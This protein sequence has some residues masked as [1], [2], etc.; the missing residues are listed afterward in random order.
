MITVLHVIESLEIGGAEHQLTAMLLRSDRR[1]FHHVVC[2]LGTAS[3]YG[4]DLERA[5]FPVYALALSPPR[6]LLPAFLRLRRLVSDIRPDV[7][8]VSLFWSGV[9]GRFIARLARIP[10]LT[11]LVNTSYEPEWVEEPQ[12]HP[13]KVA[14]V[15]W[16]DA[17]TSRRWG[18]WFLSISEPIKTSAVRRLGLDPARITIVPRGLEVER[19]TSPGPHEVAALR[20]DLW[21]DASPA[22]LSVGRLV[23][24]K[25]YRYAIEAMARVVT[26]FPTARLCIAGEG[27]LRGK[28]TALVH[29]LGLDDHVRLLGSRRDVPALLAACDLFIFPQ[30]FGGFGNAL[31]EAMAMGKSCVVARYLG[32]EEV[33]A[34]GTAALVVP[35]RSA[36]ELA[37]GVIDLVRNPQ[38]ADDLGQKAAA[39][40]WGRYDIAVS[41]RGLEQ[42][43][44]SLAQE[45]A[46]SPALTG[47][48]S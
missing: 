24:Q 44:A 25:G 36:E 21:S 46:H 42:L 13:M 18:T 43:C 4:A 22:I 7:L 29:R 45:P 12:L 38:A 23:P 30:L 20:R 1:R 35:L 47:S 32:A 6:D 16:L 15:R 8:H 28:L 11:S 14:V 17:F 5:G 10:V 41:S 2:A 31:V 3:A 27:P 33:T 26:Q 39:W 48:P 9:L 37:R 34:N 19:L 40:A